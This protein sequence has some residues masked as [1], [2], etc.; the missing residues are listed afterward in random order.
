MTSVESPAEAGPSD[1]HNS[2]YLAALDVFPAVP[3]SS[4]LVLT[5]NRGE[6]S[7]RELYSLKVVVTQS[8]IVTS[9]SQT[10]VFE[11]SGRNRRDKDPDDRVSRSTPCSG[12][13][14]DVRV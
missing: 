5:L 9:A 8:A 11:I 10:T 6:E 7:S 1:R 13:Q 4:F 12:G 3:L 14:R 2:R